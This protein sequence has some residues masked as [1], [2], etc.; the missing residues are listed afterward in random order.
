MERYVSIEEKYNIEKIDEGFTTEKPVP[1]SGYIIKRIKKK[2]PGK[3]IITGW[4][5]TKKAGVI[6]K[7]VKTGLS[8]AQ[9]QMRARK[10]ART[11]KARP[12]SQ[13]KKIKKSRITRKLN[14]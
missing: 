6:A 3:G 2:I 4:M 13:R 9:L 10:A 7:K 14:K 5:K 12:S 11:L 1:E 8:R